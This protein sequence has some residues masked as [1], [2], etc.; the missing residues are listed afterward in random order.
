MMMEIHWLKD[1]M[2]QLVDCKIDMMMW[3][4]RMS[5]TALLEPHRLMAAGPG[6]MTAGAQPTHKRAENQNYKTKELGRSWGLLRAR[7]RVTALLMENKKTLIKNTIFTFY[8]SWRGAIL[9]LVRFWLVTGRSSS[10]GRRGRLILLSRFALL[11]RRG[12]WGGGGG[13]VRR[14]G[15]RGEDSFKCLALSE[16]TIFRQRIAGGGVHLSTQRTF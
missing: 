14:L 15:L 7:M 5:E 16:T 1:T 3:V 6:C 13:V 4:T 12:R 11:V 9:V 8:W 2:N 10:G